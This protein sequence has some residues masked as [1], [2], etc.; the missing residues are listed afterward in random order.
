MNPEDI[1]DDFLDVPEAENDL[2]NWPYPL[3]GRDNVGRPRTMESPE[4]FDALVDD[5]LITAA[6]RKQRPTMTGMYLHLGMSHSSF[7]EYPKIHPEYSDSVKRARELIKASYENH[8][9]QKQGSVQGVMFALKN[10]GRLDGS[11]IDVSRTELTGKDGKP[12]AYDEKLNTMSDIEKVSRLLHMLRKQAHLA[13]I[14]QSDDDS[15]DD[16][17]S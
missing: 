7:H 8:L 4:Q 14:T 6:K 17:L 15:D 3:P 11:F 1:D 16:P 13:D 5:Y 12:I 9:V 2:E 10:F